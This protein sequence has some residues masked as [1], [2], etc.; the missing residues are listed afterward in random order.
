MM[1]LENDL[2]SY[3]QQRDLERVRRQLEEESAK[4]MHCVRI[5]DFK[6]KFHELNAEM[7]VKFEAYVTYLEFSE[8]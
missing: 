6:D 2:K 3:A 1:S 7:N 4:I 5:N 8:H